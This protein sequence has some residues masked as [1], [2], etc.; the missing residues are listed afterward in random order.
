VLLLDEPTSGLDPAGRDA[1]LRLVRTLGTD[2]GKSVILSTHLLADVEAVCER[3]VI[4]AGGRVRGQGTVAELCA[5]RLDRYRIRVQGDPTGFRDDLLSEGVKLLADNGQ[6]EW[7]VAVPA[8]W[9][10]IAFFKLA[11]VNEVVIRSLVPD[12]ETLEEL[13]LRTVGG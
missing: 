8:G 9:T 2:H 3:V 7:R 11:E 6:G 13:F 5:R 1:M 10:N 12:D 4:L